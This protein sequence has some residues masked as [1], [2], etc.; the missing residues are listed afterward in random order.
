MNNNIKKWITEYGIEFL[1]NIGI[2]KGDK[3]FDCC[4]G[5]GNYSIP[6]AKIVGPKGLVYALEMNKSKLN[7]LKET[8]DLVKVKNIKI[9]DTEFK[10][11]LPLSSKSIDIILLYDIFWYFSLDDI[12]LSRLINEVYRISKDSVIFSVYPEHVDKNKLKLKIEKANFL[13]EKEI[14]KTLVHDNELKT[15]QVW[16]FR[17][18]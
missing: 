17:K 9:I 11:T 12:R 4:C 7:T 14:L 16:N 18:L 3:V 13:L 6:A 10:A 2:K 5:E 15:G 8:S 1:I